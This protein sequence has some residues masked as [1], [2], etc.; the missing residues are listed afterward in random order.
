MRSDFSLN[1]NNNYYCCCITALFVTLWDIITYSYKFVV[2]C[3][4]VPGMYYVYKKNLNAAKP[5]VISHIIISSIAG[6]SINRV[7]LTTLLVVN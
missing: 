5:S 3:R 4:T 6:V 2:S 1:T 7:R